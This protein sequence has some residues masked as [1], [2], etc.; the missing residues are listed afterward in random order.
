MTTPPSLQPAKEIV[1]AL[2]IE[3]SRT[4][5]NTAK[6][7]QKIAKMVLKNLNTFEKKM[8]KANHYAPRYCQESALLMMISEYINQAFLSLKI[9]SHT[10]QHAE[11]E[12]QLKALKKTLHSH[13]LDEALVAAE[14]VTTH[15][16]HLSDTP[17]HTR[18]FSGFLAFVGVC[19][20]CIGASL[21]IFHIAFAPAAACITLGTLMFIFG[22]AIY[23]ENSGNPK[24]ITTTTRVMLEK[25]YLQLA[26]QTSLLAN[27]LA[28]LRKK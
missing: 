20:F 7:A 22:I 21:F 27:T 23:K 19:L 16:T 9:L 1:H 26:S 28:H 13:Y 5:T 18:I 10:K 12:S 3:L 15:T 25:C 14:A 4:P 2:L 8:A 6:E 17:K 11:I 24:T